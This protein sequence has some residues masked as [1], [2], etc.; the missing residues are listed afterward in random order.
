MSLAISEIPFLSDCL[1]GLSSGRAAD[2]WCREVASG[3][4]WV[5]ATINSCDWLN[6]LV[7][8]DLRVSRYPLFGHSLT[9]LT[10]REPTSAGATE[11]SA[12]RSPASQLVNGNPKSSNPGTAAAG[13]AFDV[14]SK[15]AGSNHSASESKN[16]RSTSVTEQVLRL[17]PQA[18]ISLLRRHAGRDNSLQ[19]LQSQTVKPRMQ[20]T[21]NRAR[22]PDD[23][24][25][26]T[27][28]EVLL[29]RTAR[30]AER[31]WL[32]GAPDRRA[33]DRLTA[34]TRAPSA[35]SPSFAAHWSKTLAGERASTELLTLLANSGSKLERSS[36]GLEDRE[37]STN[38]AAANSDT[39][40]PATN[41]PWSRP[42]SASPANQH[43][44]GTQSPPAGAKQALVTGVESPSRHF[45]SDSTSFLSSPLPSHTVGEIAEWP[46]ETR[47]APPAIS[48]SLVTLR[49]PANPAVPVLPIAGATAQRG[50]KT[51]EAIAQ[52]DDLTALGRKIERLLNQ[53]A[54]RHG[55][56][57]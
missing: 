32:A 39:T 21:S 43:Y 20:P 24:R 47:L 25:R 37:R 4:Q 54:R 33:F 18:D 10:N 16:T 49:P 35:S 56:D 17:E 29:A 11:S 8:I 52:G 27:T 41:S 9:A 26:E 1:A 13:R 46:A 57:V 6:A 55:I 19:N 51:E 48:P 36:P 22:V 5:T 31:A 2:S 23:L 40:A 38:S 28:P 7:E 44:E 3:T 15:D 42:P 14:S 53:E 50:A 45:A 12:P 30:R 34:N